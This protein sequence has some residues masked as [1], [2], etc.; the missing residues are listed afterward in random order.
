MRGQTVHQPGW[1]ERCHLLVLSVA[2]M[3]VQGG[4][5]VSFPLPPHKLGPHDV[6]EIRP[7]K[8]PSP[9]LAS[10][11]VYRIKDDVIILAVEELPEAGLDQPLRLDKL[12][13]VV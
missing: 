2:T 10:G 7:H 6:V 9:A 11:V 8:G 4:G 5:S 1:L 13:N 3:P 12:A